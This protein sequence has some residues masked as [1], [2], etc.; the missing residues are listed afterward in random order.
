MK[1]NIANSD[2]SHE[3]YVVEIDGGTES[4]HGAYFEALKAG[5]ELKQTTQTKRQSGIN[6]DV[7]SALGH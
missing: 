2:L 6:C 4:R 1:T 3:W 7:M 5:M